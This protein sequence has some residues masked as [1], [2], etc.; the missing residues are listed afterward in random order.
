MITTKDGVIKKRG[1]IVYERAYSLSSKK[2][3]PLKSIVHQTLNN[4]G[5][6]WFDKEKCQAECDILNKNSAPLRL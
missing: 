5:N 4:E 1:E 2:Y 6:A 3:I